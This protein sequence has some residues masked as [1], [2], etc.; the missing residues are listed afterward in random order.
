MKRVL[1]IFPPMWG[2]AGYASVD[3][4]Y[5][6][7]IE[8]YYYVPR[9]Q[10]VYLSGPNWVFSY[11]LPARCRNYDLYSGYKV[12]CSG[13]RPY[14]HFSDH[15]V[16][17]ARYRNYRGHQQCWRDYRGRDDYYDGPRGHGHGHYKHHG[18]GHDRDHGH[19]HGRGHGRGHHD[20]D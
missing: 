15:R 5:L 13:P 4:Y 20:H 6:P 10:F 8:C 19:G 2:P 1:Q 12:V 7:D 9:R 11:N 17:Y 18:R 16:T 3:Y 14:M